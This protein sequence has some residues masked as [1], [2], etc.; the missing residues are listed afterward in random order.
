MLRTSR[1]CRAASGSNVRSAPRTIPRVPSRSFSRVDQSAAPA[2]VAPTTDPVFDEQTEKMEKMN[3]FTAINNALG[4]A[5]ESDPKAYVS[6][7][8]TIEPTCWMS[9]MLSTDTSL[10]RTSPLAECFDAL[11]I[12]AN[13][14]ANTVS[15]IPHCLSKELLVSLLAWRL[16]A[17]PQS[18]RCSLPITSSLPSIRCVTRSSLDVSVLTL[19][20][21]IIF[22]RL[23]CCCF[24]PLILH[25]DCE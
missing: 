2:R 19:C 6:A 8:C 3:L 25:T 17:I 21:L 16:W 1:P 20:L 24:V 9:V 22:A 13:A 14:S 12:C 4:I 7:S 5:L 15:S 18:L 11:L 23:G 10:V